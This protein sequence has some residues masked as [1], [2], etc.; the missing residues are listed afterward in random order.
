MAGG[1][2]W[3]LKLKTDDY[4]SW[5]KT[6]YKSD[7]ETVKEVQL[8]RRLVTTFEIYRRIHTSV[9]SLGPGELGSESGSISCL[10][11][12]VLHTRIG[13]NATY[14]CMGDGLDEEQDQSAYYIQRQ[15]W[16]RVGKD[17]KYGTETPE[18]TPEDPPS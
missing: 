12:G 4:E 5:K 11:G 1:P 3:K 8:W 9:V 17:E 18:P 13:G 2:D 7:N 16:I 14:V 10:V 6:I 15:K